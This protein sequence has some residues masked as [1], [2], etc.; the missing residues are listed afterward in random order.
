MKKFIGSIVT[1]S[2]IGAGVVSPVQASQPGR[3]FKNP[4]M[5]TSVQVQQVVVKPIMQLPAGMFDITGK[6]FEVNLRS[7]ESK[8]YPYSWLCEVRIKT[9]SGKVYSFLSGSYYQLSTFCDAGAAA[10]ESQN[11]VRVS[12]FVYTQANGQYKVKVQPIFQIMRATGEAV[13]AMDQLTDF[14]QPFSDKYP[15]Q[16]KSAIQ[17]SIGIMGTVAE[18]RNMKGDAQPMCEAWLHAH[19]SDKK[20]KLIVANGAVEKRFFAVRSCR[21]LSGAVGS[22]KLVRAMGTINGTDVIV[23]NLAEHREDRAEEILTKYF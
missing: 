3:G 2:I 21:I 10:L 16:L 22:S 18:F 7:E 23:M 20:V 9:T 4:H 12:G 17:S 13:N 5:A 14:S 15:A 6:V 19:N 11:T 1:I 8:I